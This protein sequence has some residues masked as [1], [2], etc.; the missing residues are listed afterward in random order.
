MHMGLAL[1]WT[2]IGG[3]PKRA[4]GGHPWIKV[5]WV[6]NS[7]RHALE[8]SGLWRLVKG[9]NPLPLGAG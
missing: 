7:E 1:F 5:R 9:N 6:C 3:L 8:L 2:T 4:T